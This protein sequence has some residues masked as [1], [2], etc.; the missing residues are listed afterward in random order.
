[1]AA[2]NE[3]LATLAGDLKVVYSNVLTQVLPDAAILQKRYPLAKSGDF[4][5]VGDFFSALIGLQFPWGFS[6]LGQGTEG[7]ATNYTLG[8]A[9]AG[10]T[11]PAQIYAN[12]TVLVDNLQYQIL[13]RANSSGG[14]QAVLSAMSY[15]GEQMAIN[16]RNV[17]ELQIL[18]GREGLGIS[19]GAISTLTVT[20]TDGSTSPGI[21]SL[22]IGARVQWMQSNLTSARTV[23]DGS[24]YLTVSAVNVGTANAL[25]LTMVATGT[26]NVAAITTNDVMY[27][28]GSRG[29]AVGSGDTSVPQ[30]EQLG[31]ALQLRP[32]TGTQFGI[33]KAL[34]VGWVANQLPTIGTLTP[35]ALMNA[36]A[37]ALGRGGQLG[38]YLAV[39]SPAS[40]AVLNSALATNEIYNN[41]QGFSMSKKTGTDDIMVYNGGIK[42]E[43]VSHPLQK[44]GLIYLFPAK[45]LHR[46]GSTD[47]TFAVPGR[48]EG[49]E[50][51]FPVNGVAAM[52]RQC[53]ADFQ[54]VLLTPPSGCYLS[55]ITY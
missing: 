16:M 53:R 42:V 49:D 3:T 11:K 7:T 25:T 37:L 50:Y 38:D 1:M 9:L 12:T 14:K 21:L 46:I 19:V 44:T 52:Q 39:M 40:W 15:T 17:L 13:D 2:L 51:Y 48:P 32:T 43:C 27:I 55:G 28:A 6:F 8:D 24:N 4:P 29:V 33:D 10:Q 30:Y 54:T 26:T 23:N 35:S 41:P 47:M 5:P 31:L 34:Y 45:E 22:L 18:H 20:F 36:A